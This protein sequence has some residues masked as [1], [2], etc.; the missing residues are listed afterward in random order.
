MTSLARIAIRFQHVLSDQ[1]P[2]PVPEYTAWLLATPSPIS[3]LIPSA[4]QERRV[5][6]ETVFDTVV[7]LVP[8]PVNANHSGGD[9]AF[10]L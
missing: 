2:N 9:H 4:R 1:F 5:T 10:L 8:W 7:C 6:E 3:L